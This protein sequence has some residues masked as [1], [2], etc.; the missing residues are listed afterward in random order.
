MS[1]FCTVCGKGPQ[2]GNKV[3]HSNRKSP[4]RF[5]ANLQKIKVEKNG[6][7]KSVKV[8]TSC[9]KAGKVTKVIKSIS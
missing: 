4:R 6:E 7:V 1:N 8:C 5:N 3:S 9:L 2:F